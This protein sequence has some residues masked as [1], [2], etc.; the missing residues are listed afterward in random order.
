[1]EMLVYN[2]KY[3]WMTETQEDL[4]LQKDF[5]VK[6]AKIGV[7]FELKNIFFEP[8]KIFPEKKET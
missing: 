2:A 7:T 5:Q 8:K 4:Q 1:M 6:R 3:N